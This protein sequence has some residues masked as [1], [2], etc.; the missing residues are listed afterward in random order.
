MLLVFS[1]LFITE[2]MAWP[3]LWTVIPVVSV[4]LLIL[5]G[6]LGANLTSAFL[7][8][9]PMV[10]IGDRSYSLYLWHWPF[11]VFA[12][13][14]VPGQPLIVLGAAILS[15]VP[16][17]ISY[18]FVEQ[19]VRLKK[20]W[21]VPRSTLL[22]G[23]VLVIPAVLSVVLLAGADRG[24]GLGM[25]APPKH[26]ASI[27]GCTDTRFDPQRCTWTVPGSKGTLMLVGDSQA[28]SYSDAVVTAARNLTLNTVIAS[29]SA[30]P[31]TGVGT[32]TKV[33][34]YCSTWQREV[35]SFALE[36]RPEVVLIANRIAGY[37][38]P[39]WNWVVA[40]E[41][42]G[43]AS[44]TIARSIENWNRGMTEVIDTLERAGI[45]VL[46]L[47]PIPDMNNRSAVTSDSLLWKLTG[48]GP[49]VPTN[50]A[51][52]GELAQILAPVNV[53]N[54]LILEEFP[55]TVVYSPLDVLCPDGLNCPS[56]I[57]GVRMY[58]DWGHLTVAGSKMLVPGL[59][60]SIEIATRR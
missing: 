40:A 58:L 6:S 3:S 53:A 60:K 41:P 1:L 52:V 16:A 27:N 20:S 10:W 12:A 38:H 43:T 21:S 7:G 25:T 14:L 18:T 46:L 55:E 32:V 17:L 15:V 33:D 48:F 4:L 54:A 24:W 49:S 28:D 5:A 8:S 59:E 42:D 26:V 47:N 19:P 30:C 37:V 34:G 51:S 44:K 39:E 9:R 35:L 23:V 45:S 2:A 31:F 22:I 29:K 57:R 13:I 50:Q 56:R 11:I 36:S